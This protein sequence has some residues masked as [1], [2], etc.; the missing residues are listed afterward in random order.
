MPRLAE[1][2]KLLDMCEVEEKRKEN[3]LVE[4]VKGIIVDFCKYGYEDNSYTYESF[5][6][7]FPDLKHIVIA[8]TTTDDD[9]HEI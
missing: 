3:P 1:L 4:Y 5:D 7:L 2:N 9:K 8:Y 6:T